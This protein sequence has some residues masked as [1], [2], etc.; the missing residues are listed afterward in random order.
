V[1]DSIH[2]FR[3]P[4]L[5]ERVHYDEDGRLKLSPRTEYV[6]HLYHYAQPDRVFAE[7]DVLWF[8]STS[9][10]IQ[11]VSNER[12][13]IDS[14]YD[15]KTFRFRTGSPSDRVFDR[16]S[17]VRSDKKRREFWEFDLEVTIR[18]DRFRLVCFAL[19]VGIALWIPQ[20]VTMLRNEHLEPKWLWAS[21]SLACYLVVGL[22][23]AFGLKKIV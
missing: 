6:I 15:R 22:V 9:S 12:L 19:L 13:A 18:D 11:F 3:R 7:G 23:G 16:I 10:W 8:R 14:P 21:V 20:L 17:V 1:I 5:Q 2:R 4:G